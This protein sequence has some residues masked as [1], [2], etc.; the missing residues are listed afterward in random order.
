LKDSH[1]FD[2]SGLI[3][4]LGVKIEKNAHTIY[5]GNQMYVIE[6]QL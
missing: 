6:N 4:N 2:F 1:L 5:V 3:F